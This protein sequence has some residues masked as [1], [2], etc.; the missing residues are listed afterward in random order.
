VL[1]VLERAVQ[2]GLVKPLWRKQGQNPVLQRGQVALRG[3]V[4][5]ALAGL[6][7]VLQLR[8]V[9]AEPAQ[10]QGQ[11]LLFLTI[12]QINKEYKRAGAGAAD[13]ANTRSKE[14]RCF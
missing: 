9:P 4:E 8:R 5:Q 7:P 11:A 14:W 2:Q 10:G 1:F 3:Q 6:A 12:R 13:I